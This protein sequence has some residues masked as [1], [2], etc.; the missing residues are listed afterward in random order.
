M[1]DFVSFS[2]LS[3]RQ[4]ACYVTLLRHK[5]YKYATK[6][7]ELHAGTYKLPKLESLHVTIRHCETGL[8]EMTR[9]VRLNMCPLH[10]FM[11]G[12]LNLSLR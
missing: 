11:H 7:E 5:L 2:S 12:A 9:L 6:I 1:Q 3:H 8:R 4:P 10:L